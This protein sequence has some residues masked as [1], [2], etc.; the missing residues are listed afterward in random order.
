M[1]K[2]HEDAY[3]PDNLSLFTVNRE[4]YR[5]PKKQN[6]GEIWPLWFISMLGE[7]CKT[8]FGFTG[9]PGKLQKRHFF[10]L[11]IAKEIA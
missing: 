11:V 7:S 9:C 6:Y 5:E 4:H 8:I 1:V 3:W 2:S 10:K